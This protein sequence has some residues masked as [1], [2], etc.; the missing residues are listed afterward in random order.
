MTTLKTLKHLK[1]YLNL[2]QNVEHCKLVMFKRAWWSVIVW[3][4]LDNI[5][6]SV[7]RITNH[8]KKNRLNFSFIPSKF[9]FECACNNYTKWWWSKWPR[10]TESAFSSMF[11]SPIKLFSFPGRN[12]HCWYLGLFSTPLAPDFFNIRF[13]PNV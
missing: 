10:K 8:A 4:Q 7:K 12:F 2:K 5:Y 9:V 3:L 1:K 6:P 13:F 11:K